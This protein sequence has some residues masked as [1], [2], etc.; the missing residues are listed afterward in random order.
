MKGRHSSVTGELERKMALRKL[1]V[2]LRANCHHLCLDFLSCFFRIES[3]K[4]EDDYVINFGKSESA[5]L[6]VY[7]L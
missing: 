2:D 1:R 5:E 7:I 6:K 3:S 4:G